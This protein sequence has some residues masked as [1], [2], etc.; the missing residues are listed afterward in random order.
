M[1]HCRFGSNPAL[2][3]PS[4][5]VKLSRNPTGRHMFKAESGIFGAKTTG[6]GGTRPL[7][8]PLRLVQRRVGRSITMMR[9]QSEVDAAIDLAHGFFWHHGRVWT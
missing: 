8:F 3:N 7:L 6:V 4:A 9:A 1:Q 2:K 5:L